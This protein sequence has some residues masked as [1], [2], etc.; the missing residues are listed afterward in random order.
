[1][2][3]SYY[4][5]SPSTHQYKNS[6][7]LIQSRAFLITQLPQALNDHIL[8]V[9]KLTKVIKLAVQAVPPTLD[10]CGKLYFDQDCVFPFTS[11]L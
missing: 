4:P 5:L 6:K 1:M 2:L 7:D 10:I 9:N 3:I 8:E 11:Q